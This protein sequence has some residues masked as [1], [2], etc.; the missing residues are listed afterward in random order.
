MSKK[1]II[2]CS[3]KPSST[4]HQYNNI[5]FLGVVDSNYNFIYADICK[6]N[7]EQPREGGLLKNSTFLQKINTNTINL[8]AACPF[9]DGNKN[10]PYVFVGDGSFGLEPHIME[11]FPGYH[12]PETREEDF[13]QRLAKTRVGID[14]IFGLITSV[15]GI[16]DKPVECHIEKAS[17]L[18]MCCVLLHNFLYK[19]ESSRCLYAPIGAGDYIE[20]GVI[21]KE[22]SWRNVQAKNCLRSLKPVAH[23]PSVN[24]LDVR[25]E[26]ANYFYNRN[27]SRIERAV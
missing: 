27:K 15:F 3:P 21:V 17:T 23:Y 13:N 1:I 24:A 19:S 6:P 4:Y 12:E 22:G 2:R 9:Q 20:N 25:T 26:F 18:V 14:N 10:V 8:P 11:P 5:I 16:F 7:K